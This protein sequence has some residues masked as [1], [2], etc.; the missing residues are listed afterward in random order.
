MRRGPDA[1]PA[2]VLTV[3]DSEI[4]GALAAVADFADLKSPFFLGHSA[5]TAMLAATAAAAVGLSPD[6]ACSVRR[7]ALVHDVGR[8]GI[9]S[10]IWDRPGPLSAEQWERVRLH[11]Y[12]GERVLSRCALLAPY[13]DMAARHHERADGSG[14]HRGLAGD[15]LTV[16]ARLLAAADVYQ[17]MTQERAHRPALAPADAAARLLDAVDGGRFGAPRSTLCWPR[18]ARPAGRRTSAGRRD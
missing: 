17:A 16:E 7:A 4:D 18:P 14:Y 8:V 1:E 13:V 15:Q 10:G 5:G 2:P 6:H 9:P 3:D 11:S 12:L